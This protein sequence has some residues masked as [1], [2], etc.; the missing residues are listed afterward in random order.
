MN[1]FLFFLHLGTVALWEYQ[2]VVLHNKVM[3]AG[4]MEISSYLGSS[5]LMSVF[6]L[7]FL[8]NSSQDVL[9]DYQRDVFYCRRCNHCYQQVSHFG[10][11]IMTFMH[12]PEMPFQPL[13]DNSC[14]QALWRQGM[15]LVKK[16][17]FERGYSNTDTELLVMHLKCAV[18][19]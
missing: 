6:P 1:M 18:C 15:F 14:L 7:S 5:L 2:V 3:E 11:A 8:A 4:K 12:S 10:F 13:G 9:P 17:S 19:P 16:N